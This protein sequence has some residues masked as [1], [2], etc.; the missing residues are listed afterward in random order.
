[1]S[2]MQNLNQIRARHVLMF[3]TRGSVRGQNQGE[4]VKKIPPVILNSGL[5]AALA[6]SMDPK[7]SGWKTVFDGIA[8]HLASR[9]IGLV[10]SGVNT[11]ELLLDFLAEENTSS[12]KLRDAT[13]EAMLWLEFA[14]RLV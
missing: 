9:E 14:R 6:Y 1:M 4:V 13:D 10:P 7:Q 8:T 11:A 3:A 2:T 12:A 5:L